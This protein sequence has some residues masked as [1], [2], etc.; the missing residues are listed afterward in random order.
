MVTTPL[1]IVD[2]VVDEGLGCFPVSKP[3]PEEQPGRAIH[4]RSKGMVVL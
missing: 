3:G 1:G 2:Q 4:P